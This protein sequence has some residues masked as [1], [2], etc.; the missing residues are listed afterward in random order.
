METIEYKLYAV[1]FFEVSHTNAVN[2]QCRNVIYT[3]RMS[4]ALSSTMQIF[5][6]IKN[7]CFRYMVTD[8]I[9]ANT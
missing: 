6:P 8:A 7:D 5:S 9:S 2:D 4:T 1:R 3:G